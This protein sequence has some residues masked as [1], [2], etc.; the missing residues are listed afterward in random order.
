[1]SRQTI[2]NI[3]LKENIS[4][5][6]INR[7]KDTD[8]LYIIADEKW[9]HTQRN[10]RRK[11]M[12]KAIVVFDGIISKH[13]RN[14]LNNKRTFSGRNECFIY[15]VIDYI[16]TAY[17]ISKIKTFYIL[18]D[19]ASWIKSLKYYFNF[20]PN[21]EVIQALDKFHLKQCLWRIMP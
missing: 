17:D 18:G 9:I 19:G 5:P 6:K 4:I 2:R 1:M 12:Q 13:E 16:E 8:V 3:I 15:D 20:N 14:I 11:V 7:L 10:K 21:I